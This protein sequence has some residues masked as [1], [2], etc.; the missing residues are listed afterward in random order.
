M[1]DIIICKEEA[2]AQIKKF[3]KAWGLY[4]AKA[5]ISGGK[6]SSIPMEVSDLLLANVMTGGISFSADGK[7]I[8][9]EISDPIEGLENL[10]FSRKLR[11]SDIREIQEM[12]DSEQPRGIAQACTDITDYQL[13]ELTSRDMG[14]LA[15]ITAHISFS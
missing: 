1:Q 4:D 14:T 12:P 8:S 11:A 10:E 15:C 9:M 2:Q 3:A 7:K 13:S 5:V 6:E